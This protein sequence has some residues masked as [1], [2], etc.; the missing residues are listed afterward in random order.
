MSIFQNSILKNFTQDESQVALR[1]A[2]FQEYIKKIDY[3]KTVKEEKYQDG[4]LKDIF[5]SC[6]GYT[7]DSENPQNYN[8]AREE[9]NEQNS[10][11][12]DAVI[13][14]NGKVIGVIELKDQSTKNLNNIEDQAFNYHNSHTNSKYIIISNFDELRFYIDKR[15][16]FEKFNL[17]TLNYEEF[18]K[19]HLLLCFENIKDDIPLRLK[20]KSTSFETAISK[21]LYKD[22]SNFRAKLF[23]NIV[24]NN[25]LLEKSQALRLTQKLCDRIIFILFAEDRALLKPN[26]IDEIAKEFENQKFT[27]YSLYEMFKIYFEAINSGNE[28]LGIAKYNGGLF[29][30]DKL[31]DSLKIDDDILQTHTKNLSSY[32]FASEISVNILG[33]IF[34]QSLSDLEEIEAQIDNVEFDKTK[35]KRKKDG[36][37]Y[38]PSYI[39]KYIVD[40]TLGELCSQKR[41]ELE[42]KQINQP[43]N[44]KKLTKQEQTQK[45]NL[46]TYK[47]WLLNIKILDPACGSG[48]FLNAAMEFLICEHTQLSNELALFSDLFVSY[49]LEEDILEHNLYG[50]DINENAVEIARLSLWLRSAKKGRSLVSL[51]QKIVCANS[52]L[53]Q[54]FENNSFDIVIGNPPYIM[55]DNNKNAFNGLH[56]HECYQGKTD[57]WHLFTGLGIN[58]AKENGTISYIAKN[59]WFSSNA[60]SKMRAKIYKETHIDK[61]IDFGVNIIFENVGQQTMIFILTKTNKNENHKIN[62]FIK[63]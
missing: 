49:M 18:K 55:E 23:E 47:E 38:T 56:S 50:V 48:A 43:K 58:L 57:I 11:K 3:I 14:D 19:L 30:E 59:Q 62:F 4:F 22:F 42:L 26:T 45:E 7:L 12:A 29:L 39:T 63:F 61:I 35:S 1:W 10:K 24:Q 31:L 41:V 52:L 17:F 32:D 15:T 20:E 36:V 27:S 9:K 2:K 28:K 51:N 60:A 54:P 16:A 5:V 8:L 34:E 13:K 53:E 44:T 46:Q 6:L 25:Q 37:F 40:N 21:K 33:H